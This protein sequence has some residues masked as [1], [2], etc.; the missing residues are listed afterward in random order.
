MK[1]ASKIFYAI[2]LTTILTSIVILSIVYSAVKQEIQTNF[3]GY[4]HALGQNITNFFQQLEKLSDI[5][6][7]NAAL[8]IQQKMVNGYIPSN[9]T[10]AIVFQIN[11]FTFYFPVTASSL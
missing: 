5:I 8:L 10:L 7:K 11:I 2:M 3:T 9:K 1:F 6:S 4:Y